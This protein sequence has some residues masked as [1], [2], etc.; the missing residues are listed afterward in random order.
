[1]RCQFIFT[2]G[3]IED[4]LVSQYPCKLEDTSV[5]NNMTSL[6]IG[7]HPCPKSSSCKMWVEGPNTGLTSFDDIFVAF[8]T[9]FQVMTLEGWTEIFYLVWL[10]ASS[11]I[12]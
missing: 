5:D 3:K 7:L 2:V 1:M 8:L 6:D 12:S 10:F 11:Q 9:V 4:I